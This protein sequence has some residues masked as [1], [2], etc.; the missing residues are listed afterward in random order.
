MDGYGYEVRK[1]VGVEPDGKRVDIALWLDVKWLHGLP[2]NHRTGLQE[3]ISFGSEPF[4]VIAENK[5]HFNAAVGDDSLSFLA[6]LSGHLQRPITLNK[7]RQVFGWLVRLIIHFA[8]WLFVRSLYCCFR[9]IISK[10]LIDWMYEVH[11]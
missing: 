9:I 6:I 4:D 3:K 7:W 11:T 10:N 5:G 1:A 2:E 8:R